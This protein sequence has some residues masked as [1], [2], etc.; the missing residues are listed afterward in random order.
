MCGNQEWVDEKLA[1]GDVR[2]GTCYLLIYCYLLSSF[3]GRRVGLKPFIFYASVLLLSYATPHQL[4]ISLLSQSLVK[5][6]RLALNLWPR[7]IVSQLSE[8][9]RLQACTTRPDQ[10]L[11]QR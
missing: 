5:L 6:L 11:L 1:T 2:P 10:S 8:Q 9:L 4:F 7:I 3:C